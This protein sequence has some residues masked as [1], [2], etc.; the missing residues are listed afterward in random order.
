MKRKEQKSTGYTT[1]QK[2]HEVTREIPEVF[3]KLEQTAKTSKKQWKWQRG[4][5]T[6]PLTASQ[7][8]RAIS[9]RDNGVGEAQE[10]G[11]ASGRL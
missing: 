11:H 10:P 6:H 8:N 3:R 4:I 9:A 1:A 7:W 2:W 5:A